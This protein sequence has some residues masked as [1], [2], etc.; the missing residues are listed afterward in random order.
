MGS[1]RAWPGLSREG[2]EVDA[3]R[4]GLRQSWATHWGG[5]GVLAPHAAHLGLGSVL[6]PTQ[7]PHD[8]WASEGTP[9]FGWGGQ[10]GLGPG[11]RGRW[12]F[13]KESE[14]SR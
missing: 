6:V 8:P 7:P 14:T 11:S 2:A 9:A 10:G 5:A 12:G 1:D 3:P 13:G 4:A